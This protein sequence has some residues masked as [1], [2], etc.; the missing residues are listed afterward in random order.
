MAKGVPTGIGCFSQ[1]E[2]VFI[3]RERYDLHEL[4]APGRHR[5]VDVDAVDPGHALDEPETSAGAFTVDEILAAL[6]GIEP[7]KDMRV[8]SLLDV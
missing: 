4:N 8:V 1:L 3:L 5:L 6:K 7:G 2:A